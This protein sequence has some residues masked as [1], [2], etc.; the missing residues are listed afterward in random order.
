MPSALCAG[1]S[2][3]LSPEELIAQGRYREAVPLLEAQRA[4]MAKDGVHLAL[5]VTLNNLGSAYYELSRYRDAQRVYE[6][7]LLLRRRLNDAAS[8]DA[9]RTL[10]NLG[11]VYLE[12]RLIA[13]ARDTL[14]QAARAL[15]LQDPDGLPITGVWL[16]LAT[17]YKAERR[18][19]DAEALFRRGLAARERILGPAHRD[20]AMALN[21]LGVLLRDRNQLVDAQPLLERAVA[22][23]ERTL[24]LEHPQVAAGLHN[25]GV[26]YAGLELNTRAEEC[27]D[28][29]LRIAEKALPP[30]HPNLAAYRSSYA[31]L[32][33]KT[34]HKKEAR[35][36]ENLARQGLKQSETGNLLGYT[37]EAREKPH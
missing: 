11:V 29:A 36:L 37:I 32:L 26:I 35:R 10:S 12:L 25:L 19:E 16:N 27:Y 8:R 1:E 4:S 6:E 20:V 22:I 15:E 21:N 9:A 33:G 3:P 31:L 17:A 23:W 5:V 24:G 2:Q 34:G 7:S 28:R 13:K 14:Q 30:D 18:V